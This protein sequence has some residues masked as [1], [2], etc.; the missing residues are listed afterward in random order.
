MQLR[1]EAQGKYLKKIIEEQQRLSGVVL[2]ES[3]GI[4]SITPPTLASICPESDKTEPSTPA[5]TSESPF[6]DM[7]TH[8]DYRHFNGHSRDESIS[9]HHEPLTPDSSGRDGSP[10][11]SPKSE[12]KNKRQRVESELSRG[13]QDLVLTHHILES[14]PGADFQHPGLMFPIGR[15]SL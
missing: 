8:D 11:G 3:P 6:Q 9:S 2:P 5:P 4:G 14:S 1:I 13:K 7:P 12:L 10:F 15:G